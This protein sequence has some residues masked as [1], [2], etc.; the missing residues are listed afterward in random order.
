MLLYRVLL[1]LCPARIRREDGAAMEEMFARRLKDARA[2]GRRARLWRREIL[3]LLALA[4]S[5]RCRGYAGASRTND[6]IRKAGRMD[7]IGQ[8]LRHAARRLVRSPGFTLTAVLTLALAIGANAAIFAVVQ[9]VVLNPLPYPASD[10]LIELD[11]GSVDLRVISGMGNT[12][13]LYFHYVERARSLDSAAL[14]RTVDRTLGEGSEPERI[15]VTRV[16]PSLA[17]VLRTP[18]AVGRWFSEKEGAPGAAPTAVLSHGLW[19]RRFD[20]NA[21]IVG[22]QISLDGVATEVVGI[23][24]ASFA[25]PE[26]TVDAWITEPLA[27]SMGFGLWGYLGV[28]RLRDGASI[29]TARAELSRLIPDIPAAFPGDATA[30]GNVQTRLM[31]T[32]RTLKDATIGGVTRALWMLL[33]AVGVVLI[34]ACA[35]VANLVLV[36]SEV[37][38][39]E[40]AVRRALGATRMG[41]ARYFLTESGLL[42]IAAGVLGFAI[43]AGAVRLL[44]AFGPATLPRLHELRL[45]LVTV[46]FTA[47][48]S[49]LAALVCGALPLWRGAPFVQSLHEVGR[50]NTTSRGRHR[51]RHVLMG[52]QV[53]MALVLLVAS[54]L[55]VRSLQNLR[56][57]DPGFEPS[58]GLTFRIGLPARSYDTIPD[59]VAA[60]HA[61]LER[62]ST[63]PGVARASATSCLPLAGGCAGNTVRI[64]GHTYPPGTNLP[65]A[66]FRA[67][68]G[69]YFETIGTR[70]LRG[71]GITR[72]DVDR[73]APV[74]VVNQTIAKKYFP[75]EDPIGRRIASN[76]PPS[77]PGGEPDL[78]WLTIVG[79]VADTPTRALAGPNESTRVPLL[80]I[81]M[82]RASGPGLRGSAAIGPDAAVMSYVVR[83]ATPPHALLPAIRRAVDDVDKSLAI[84][85]VRTLQDILDSAAAQMAFTMVLLAI[86]AGVTLILGAIGTYGVMSYIV[87]QR[88][89]EI[90]VRL[91]LGAEPGNV[92]GMITRQGGLV[93]LAGAAVGLGVAFAGT[94]LIGSLLYDVSPRD[95]GVFTATTMLLVA[96]AL[97]ACWLP[98]RRASRL[99][100]MEALRTE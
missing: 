41:I 66:M 54:G 99:S 6:T 40:V 4:V 46:S 52:A 50:G 80:Y 39:R 29:E 91:A 51:I 63:L 90:G 23:M 33:A 17:T 37:R 78:A 73:A 25:F 3:G 84:A 9:H 74:A 28:A 86:A 96:V 20:G 13:G 79:M 2:S 94:R 30:A 75:G 43:A 22:R 56:A 64:E 81:P 68:A 18:P 58:S 57:I 92:A 15:R 60:H 16:T 87:S 53:A 32:G 77:R 47:G 36:R 67:V 5:E 65:L 88:T 55:M 42:S 19:E 62:L 97:A 11:H 12:A 76:R 38:Q 21:A 8:E 35:N 34:V 48:L 31:F 69:D 61:I 7:R 44:L 98:A 1:R 89:G 49:L 45:D 26:P 24:P 72:S 71:R 85:Q 70:V 59:A 100:P 95:P 10:R 14:Y 93:A 83:T 82:S 27:R